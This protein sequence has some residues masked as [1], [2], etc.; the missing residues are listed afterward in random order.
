MARLPK[1]AFAAAVSVVWIVSLYVAEPLS[2][3][4]NVRDALLIGLTL[5][6]G[7]V[8]GTWWI[9]PAP[10]AG[11]VAFLAIDALSPCD[12]CRDELGLLGAAVFLTLFALLAVVIL[13]VGVGLRR[14]ADRLRA[15]R[16]RGRPGTA[17]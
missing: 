8:A 3:D 9:L 16:A 14:G 13:A 11:V 15:T 6:A 4:G 12:D 17:R 7:I 5:L 2:D 10:F 1:P